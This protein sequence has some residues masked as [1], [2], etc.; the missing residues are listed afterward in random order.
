[1][2]RNESELR[3]YLDQ[4]LQPDQMIAV[5]EHVQ[6]CAHCSSRLASIQKVMENVQDVLA[7]TASNPSS[8]SYSSRQALIKLT[9]RQKESQMK[10]IFKRPVFVLTSLVLVIAIALAFSPVRAF[11]SSFLSLFRVEQVKVVSF[12][13]AT[14]DKYQNSMQGSQDQIEQYFKQ[15]VTTT[16]QGEYQKVATVDAAANLAGFKPLVPGNTDVTSLGVNPSEHME[17]VLNTDLFNSVFEGLGHPE[18]KLPAEMNGKKVTVDVPAFVTLGIGTCAQITDAEKASIPG[19]ST[20][21]TG[22]IEMP[23]P[24]VN[25]PDGLDV[26]GLSQT[27]LQIMGMSP[28]D[29]RS[30]SESTDWTTTLVIPVP[31][32]EGVKSTQVNIGSIPGTLITDEK[33]SHYTL[34]WFKN[35]LILSLFGTGSSDAAIQTAVNIR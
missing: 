7:K 11:A 18:T 32:G 19:G 10:S 26:S 23:S 22:L 15:N 3:A 27:V 28:E 25:A 1:M 33:T 12:D 17:L 5:R 14:L 2:H 30:F 20:D 13:P 35:G 8:G 34:I 31:T 16:K 24:T 9:D 21:C 29:A 4:E 6:Q